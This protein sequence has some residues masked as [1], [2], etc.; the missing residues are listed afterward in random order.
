MKLTADVTRQLVLL[1][2]PLDFDKR[3]EFMRWAETQPSVRA[4]STSPKYRQMV[5]SSAQYKA[6]KKLGEK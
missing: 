3:A 1:A 5:Q 6:R 2:Q 4:V